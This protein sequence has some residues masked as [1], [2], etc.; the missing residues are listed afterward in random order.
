M[1]RPLL[2][3]PASD[4]EIWGTTMG[5]LEGVAL[6]VEGPITPSPRVTRA[7]TSMGDRCMT[8]RAARSPFA[9]LQV[10]CYTGHDGP[11][12]SG[13]SRASKTPSST[14][15]YLYKACPQITRAD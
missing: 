13:L 3:L 2:M 7:P 1:Y 15:V 14:N 12:A 10:N 5:R 8:R 11:E 4:V 9:R 6:V